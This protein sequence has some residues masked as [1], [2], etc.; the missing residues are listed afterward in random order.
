MN[1]KIPNGSWCLFKANVI[2]SREGK[3]VLA[4]HRDIQDPDTAGQYTIKTY[5]S[6]KSKNE[7]GWKHQKIMH[8]PDS[9]DPRYEPIVLEDDAT[10]DF[11]I[12]GEFKAVI[13]N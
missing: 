5:H 9:N 8:E 4:Q 13:Q 10:I 11:K 2:G 12:I 7:D 6:I 1:R 3:I